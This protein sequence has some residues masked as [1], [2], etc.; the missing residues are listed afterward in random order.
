MGNVRIEVNTPVGELAEGSLLLELSGL[1][2]VL[3]HTQRLASAFHATGRLVISPF[4]LDASIA[5]GESRNRVVEKSEGDR[6]EETYVFVSHD[7]RCW[8]VLDS[9]FDRRGIEKR[10]SS[11]WSA[12]L[13][14]WVWGCGPSLGGLNFGWLHLLENRW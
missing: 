2:S 9:L 3:Q 4:G 14:R 13:C 8:T 12:V 5:L 1:L 10:I 6:G 7:G 11:I